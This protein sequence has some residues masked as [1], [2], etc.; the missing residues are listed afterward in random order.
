[1][2]FG[3]GA[4]DVFSA[5]AAIRESKSG[6]TGLAFGAL[7]GKIILQTLRKYQYGTCILVA[8]TLLLVYMYNYI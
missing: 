8:P 6:D 4:P 2:A 7:L 3:N 5:I 1:M